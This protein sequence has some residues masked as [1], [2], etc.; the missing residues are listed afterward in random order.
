MSLS[1]YSD[2][3]YVISDELDDGITLQL[4]R[5]AD[6]ELPAATQEH[7]KYVPHYY[8]LVQSGMYEYYASEGQKSLRKNAQCSTFHKLSCLFSIPPHHP[9]PL[10]HSNCTI[11]TLTTTPI[12]LQSLS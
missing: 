1:L 11:C 3:T 9:T 8:T 6:Q 7:I 10:F 5:T 12:S 2:A 4:L